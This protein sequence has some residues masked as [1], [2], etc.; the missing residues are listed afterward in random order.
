MSLTDS[1]RRED[2]NALRADIR[3][4]GHI[5]GSETQVEAMMVDISRHGL[6]TDAL[7]HFAPDSPV[8][9]DLPNGK[10]L[11]GTARWQDGF[12]SGI[13]F[14]TPMD[15]AEFDGL[16]TTLTLRPHFAKRGD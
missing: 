3:V 5:S 2:R 1:P 16:I 12:W 9:I 10:S 6:G 14:D 11:T 7:M 4:S 13:L 15:Q 8:R